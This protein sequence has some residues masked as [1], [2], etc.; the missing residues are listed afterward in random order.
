[1]GA[2]GFQRDANG[3]CVPVRVAASCCVRTCALACR[4]VDASGKVQRSVSVDWDGSKKRSYDLVERCVR[5]C[6]RL[7]HLPSFVRR[8]MYTRMNMRMHA[9]MY[10]CMCNCMCAHEY[11]ST[12]KH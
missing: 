2:H 7:P 8:T 11:N 5:A 10:T 12:E 1:M 6:V 4:Y 9:G 3:R